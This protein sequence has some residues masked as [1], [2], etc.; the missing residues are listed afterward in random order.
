MRHLIWTKSKQ[1]I[2][3]C[4]ALVLVL[5]PFQT[6]VFS[7]TSTQNGKVKKF[8]LYATDGYMTLPDEEKVYIWGYSLNNE[9]GSAVYPAPT[10]EVNEGD[11][12]EITL[13]NIGP[14]KEGIRLLTHTIHWHGLDTDQ[15]ND[16]VPHTSPPIEVGKSFTYR[17][18]ATHAGTYF[19]H[20]HVDTIEHLQMGMHGSFIVKAKNGVKHAWTN[21]P[22][23]DK[24]YVFHLNE[25]DPVWHKAV[26][27][28]KPY[29]RTDFHP[30]YWTINGKAYPDTENNPDTM[31]NAKVGEKVLIRL[32]NA[33]YD[34]HPFHLHGHH[35][36]VIASD[37]RP[38]IQPLEKDTINI[39]S[40][41]RYDILVE[42]E[43]SGDY[44]FHSHKIT[45]N[46][47]NGVYPGGLHTMTRVQSLITKQTIQLILGEKKAIA[48]GKSMPLAEAPVTIDK[49]IYVPFKILSEQMNGSLT[50]DAKEKSIGFKNISY[51]V[52]L[53][54]DKDQALVNNRV[55]IMNGMLKSINGQSMIPIGI[56]TD[57]L[58][59]SSKIDSKTGKITLEFSNMEQVDDH[60]GHANNGN[61]SDSGHEQHETSEEVT[62]SNEVTVDINN[63]SFAS[64]VLKIKKGTKVTWVNKARVF[65]SVT[66]NS[67]LFDSGLLVF[68]A[69]WSYTFNE[70]GTFDYYCTTHPS[71]T[72]KVIVE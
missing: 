70:S 46:T 72:A 45:D 26:E 49:V 6:I 5:T 41:E 33:G 59:I 52:Q 7:D 37:G 16:G 18:Q 9:K 64:S 15:A 31:I 61:Q 11:Q 22:A 21:G 2:Y 4:L 68:N 58:G 36:K 17:F 56:L 24:E 29:D 50:W 42:F 1:A 10:I 55:M 25:I 28:G 27:Q 38:L 13:T 69:S 34:E 8:Q 20:C 67:N 57:M 30:R 71:M 62:E 44:P 60:S 66:E 12:V 53:W 65:H 32:I 54:I 39:G 40:G 3:A 47:N 14:K 63:L 48:N 35:F 23:Y 19:Y 51:G 43:Q